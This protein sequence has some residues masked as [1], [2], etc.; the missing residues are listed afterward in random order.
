MARSKKNHPSTLFAFIV[1]TVLVFGLCGGAVAASPRQANP[2]SR[3][4]PDNNRVR[5]FGRVVHAPAGATVQALHP[6]GAPAGEGPFQKRGGV[7]LPLSPD[8]QAEVQPGEQGRLTEHVL[9]VQSPAG[10]ASLS[11]THPAALEP[12]SLPTGQITGTVTAADTHLPLSNVLVQV[13]DEYGV[14]VYTS[15]STDSNGFYSLTALYPGSYKLYFRFHSGENSSYAPQW[16]NGQ[17]DADHANSVSV[18]NGQVTSGIDAALAVGGQI[19]GIVTAAQGGVP[20]ENVL[21]QVY[22]ASEPACPPASLCSSRAFAYTNS[23]GEYTLTG[24]ETG[25]Y[26]VSFS[27]HDYLT[28]YY[29]NRSEW[30]GADFIHVVLG[31]TTGNINAALSP[32]GSITGHVT[33]A[34]GG[35]PLAGVHV[36]AFDNRNAAEV[37]YDCPSYVSMDQTDATGAYSL[38]GLPTGEYYLKFETQGYFSSYYNDRAGLFEADPVSVTAPQTTGGIDAALTLGGRI[39]GR[40]TASMGGAPLAGMDVYVFNSPVNSSSGLV[41]QA[42]TDANGDYSVSP[43]QAGQ[44]YVGFVSSQYR[45]TY[46]NNKFTLSAADAIPVALGQTTAGIDASLDA[47]GKIS[48]TVTDADGGAPLEGVSVLVAQWIDGNYGG[49]KNHAFTNSTGQYVVAGLEPGVYSLE[50]YRGGYLPSYYNSKDNW[51]AAD[52]ISVDYNTTVEPVDAALSTG[53]EISGQVTAAEG[54]APLENAEV[55]AAVSRNSYGYACAQSDGAG[56]YL[57]TGLAAGTYYLHFTAVGYASSYYNNHPTAAQADPVTV[58]L[59]QVTANIDAALGLGS[60]IRGRVTSAEDGSPLAG[61]TVDAWFKDSDLHEARAVT[62]PQGNYTLSGLDAGKY[63]VQFLPP[64]ESDYISQYFSGKSTLMAATPVAVGANTTTDHVDASLA[65]GGR[66]SGTVTSQSGLP[67]QYVDVQATYLSTSCGQ[68]EWIQA[69]WAETDANGQ[70]TIRKLPTGTYQVGF[71]PQSSSSLY[72]GEYYNDNVSVTAPQTTGGIDAALRKGGAVMGRLTASDTGRAV[73]ASLSLFGNQSYWTYSDPYSGVFQVG[74]LEPGSYRLYIYP[75]DSPYAPEF[76][77]QKNTL[78]SADTIDIAS[79]EVV[80]GLN[81][82]VS[83]GGRFTG[84]VTAAGGGGPL[85][86]VWVLVY[87]SE[88]LDMASGYTDSQGYFAT[89]RLSSGSYRLEFRPDGS[90]AADYLDVYYDGK[91]TLD[92]ADPLDLTA[93]ADTVVNASLDLGGAI[94]GHVRDALTGMPLRGYIVRVLNNEKNEVRRLETSQSGFY[95]A[96]GLP[97]GNYYVNFYLPGVCQSKTFDLY[98]NQKPDLASADPLEV[99]IQSL[100]TGVDAFITQNYYFFPLMER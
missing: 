71:W 73:T 95:W 74:G 14:Y 9:T 94:S 13:Y 20:L 97:S 89:S 51:S 55:C 49:I 70:Y 63:T 90:A 66:I 56:Q 16:Y 85:P 92:T 52:K 72:L 84:Q 33:D 45:Q 29:D 67:L 1:C 46:Y 59:G 54:G 80:S 4:S 76:Y 30:L 19:S 43:L 53:G 22:A 10:E 44:Y 81:L 98:Y 36:Y 35:A 61:I 86:D 60:R 42:L 96:R 79:G 6:D 21:V 47:L 8:S 32:A 37:C 24:L 7:S 28:L 100:H 34:D 87:N 17:P 88:G 68:P 31:Q 2:P 15:V 12:G 27:S 77:D 5:I 18:S 93:P 69:G 26:I 50:F 62:D 65:R 38:S 3:T 11:G 99:L 64:E 40:V 39:T 83:P 58:T 57:I 25:N 82:T 75:W 23:S 78:T 48:G 41:A 91:S